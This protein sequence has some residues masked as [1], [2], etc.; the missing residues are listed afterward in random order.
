MKAYSKFLDILEKIAFVF[1]ALAVVTMMGVMMYQIIM[2]YAFSAANA[3]SEELTRYLFIYTVMLG[4]AIAVR[5][6]SHLQIDVIIGRL[7][8]RTKAIF[9]IITT[10]GGI[11]FLAFLMFYSFRLV[12]Q[13]AGTKSAGLGVT[14]NIPYFAVPVGCALMILSSIEVLLKNIAALK[15]GEEVQY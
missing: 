12:E 7:N 3:W 8:P 4:A 13:G 5:R 10:I 1:I 6:N 11:I 2:R 9:T 14:M 15:S